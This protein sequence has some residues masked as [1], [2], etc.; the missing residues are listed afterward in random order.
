MT[1]TNTYSETKVRPTG[2]ESAP[3]SERFSLSH[4]G[5]IMPKIY[6]LIAEVFSLPEQADKDA[7]IKSLVAGLE[8]AL[9]Q[10]PLLVGALEM[11]EA[12]GRM[13]VSKKKTSTLSLHVKHMLSTD[14]FPSYDELARKGFPAN[15]IA[16][17]Q[18]LPE[19]VTAKQ[20]HSPLGDNSQEG[21][22]VATFQ[23][24]FIGGGLILGAAVHHCVSDGPGCD[25]FLT[26]WAQNSAAAAEGKSFVPITP[27]RISGT[28]LDVADPSPDRIAD[29]VAAYPVVKDAG[30][31]M[32]PPPAGFQMPVFSQQ[33]WHF[34]RS[35]L[36]QLK[37]AASPKQTSTESTHV[38]NNS[39]SSWV[40]TYDAIVAL[41]WSGI[42]RA[43]IDLFHPDPETTALMVNALDTRRIWK[44]PLPGRFLGVG[45]APARSEPIAIRDIVQLPDNLPC[46][47]AAVR[48][49]IRAMTPQYV[50]GLLE[51]VAGH[52]DRRWLEIDIRSFLGMDL[53]AS[54]WQGMSA[55]SQHDFGFGLPSALRWPSPAMDGFVF[56][57]P[58]RA[59][60]PGA[61]P[62]E[63]VEL[64]V[65]LETSCQQR[66][67][68][69]EQ[70]LQFAH[71]RG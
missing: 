16:G 61:D 41:L 37:K 62:D 5:H 34:P 32:A 43:R 7:I 18:L 54:S 60:T 67:L 28:P 23:I 47:A 38:D 3:D 59:A 55:Y 53:A 4:M 12:S 44:P 68:K 14:D 50:T 30:G 70:V 46:L 36:E 65:C 25:G 27:F 19:S 33:M 31:P 26:T 64:C 49:S 29:L 57:Y 69:D 10:F 15:L 39:S 24:N 17:H 51:W 56:L 63:G 40:S 42:T 35:K 13:W 1:T 45:A 11:D 66:L 21:L 52:P 2:W 22:A 9:S 6:V 58:S 48:S 20:L 8:F 71:P